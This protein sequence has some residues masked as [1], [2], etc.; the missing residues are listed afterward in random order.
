M[1][2]KLLIFSALLFSLQFLYAQRTVT[3]TVTDV[4]SKE[5]LVGATVVITGTITGTTTDFDGNFSLEVPNDASSLTITYIGYTPQEVSI[6]GINSV[7]VSM[8]AG[9]ELDEVV[10]VGYSTQRKAD[11]T[12][13]VTPV[14]LKDI[15][16]LPAGN[17]IQNIQGR[18]PGVQVFTNGN[19]NS[20]A[21]VRIRGVGLGRLG[22]NDPLYVIDG[23]PTLSGM[24]ELNPNDIESMQVLRDAASASIYGSRAANGVII[25]T[26]KNG[27]NGLKVNLRAN[28][29]VEN[30]DFQVNPLNTEQRAQVIFQAAVNDGTNPNNA[31]P[32]YQYEWNGDFDNP[33]LNN[34]LLP[35]FID[36][37]QTMNP[38][39]TDWFNE[40]SQNSVIQDYNLSVSN[41]SER[42]RYYLSAGYYNHEGIVKESEFERIAIRMNS[43]YDIVPNK[44]TIG[45]NFTVT[46]QQANQVNDIAEGAIGLSIE[47]QTIVPI[48]T[49]D[50]VGWGGPTGGITDRDN[51]VRLIEMNKDNTNNYNRALGNIFV[52]YVPIEGLNLKSSFGVDYAFFYYRNFTKAFTAGSLN[53]EDRLSTQHNRQGNWVWSNTANYKFSLND[54]MNFDVLVGTE[55]IKFTKEYF[56]GIAQGFA[57]QDRNFAYL[58]QSTAGQLV[59]GTGDEWALN[60]YFGKFNYSLA[61]KYLLSATVR[62][63]G[64]SRFGENNRWGTFPAA[65]I[66]WVISEES[67]LSNGLF[68]FLKIRGS[69]GQNGNQEIST[70]AA[71]SIFE[72]RYATTSLFTTQQDNGTAYDISGANSG[73]LP[74]GFARTQS[75]NPDLKWETSTQTNFGLD[76]NIFNYKVSG[77]VD[78]FTK[79]T[80]DILTATR[81]LATEGEGAQRIVNGGTVENSGWEFVLGY[82]DKIGQLGFDIQGNL[83]T[84]TNEVVSLP[85]Q[86]VNSFP[87]NGQDKTILGRSVNSVYGFIADG[88][89]QN[90]AE[91]ESHATQTGAGVGRIR[92]KDLN[93]DGVIDEND[94]DFFAIF[95]NPDF[96]YGLNLSLDYKGFDLGVFFQGVSGGQIK[97]GFKIFTDFTS[98]NVGSNYGDRTLEAWSPQNTG[99]SI[100]ALTLVDNNNEAR[101]S[102][103]LWES[104]SYLKLRNL[105]FGYTPK[106]DFLEKFG[107]QSA[108]FFVQGQNILTIKPSETVAQ[109]PETPNAVFPVPKRFTVGLNLTF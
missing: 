77:S 71:L 29:S 105:S 94:Q 48:H 72:P 24:H 2:L 18:I 5:T 47:Q 28:V 22:F 52:N 33:Q 16:S 20:T 54:N 95:D 79:E 9:A 10:V 107:L 36:G 85:S 4:G 101:E 96:I 37:L 104:G 50:G 58:N 35:Q 80:K 100:P 30:F 39:N 46:N 15:E 103:Y 67:F 11:L 40:I 42:G 6:V 1:K 44:L 108:R 60:S 92:W 69:W 68:D 31:S 12:G 19:P 27:S 34:I 26:T 41:A 66:G 51:P 87:G 8:K 73:T 57:S 91:V 74:S 65:S 75:A 56:E 55:A 38:A 106:A 83:S 7:N 82:Q 88:L 93:E 90:E 62:R 99:S 3:G 76:F 81:P 53:F 63:D 49:V 13:A 78:Y 97:N 17:P 25:I 32:L 89:F 86:V 21:A 98:V 14:E 23:I 45:E 61:N 59:Y 43:E 109:D 84:A 64:S 102:S 70:R